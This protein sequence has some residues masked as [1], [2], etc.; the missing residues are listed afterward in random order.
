[1]PRLSSFYGIVI[2]MYWSE[3]HH[4]VP[5]FHAYYGEYEASLD[6]A[7][8]ILAGDL[9]KRQLRLVQ[10]WVEL[11]A[12]ELEADWARAASEQPLMPIPP[13]Q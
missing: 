6:F 9:P 5:H 8:E 12:D 11:H 3:P 10:A 1:M 7:G 2:A 13:L 4:S